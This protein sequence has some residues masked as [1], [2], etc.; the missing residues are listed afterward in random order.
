MASVFG[1]EARGRPGQLGSGAAASLAPRRPPFV[2]VSALIAS[3][4]GLLARSPGAVCTCW[5]RCQA[6]RHPGRA[7]ARRMTGVIYIASTWVPFALPRTSPAFS[8]G[9]NRRHFAA[10]NEIL[11]ANCS[12]GRCLSG[13][14]REDGS[15]RG[16]KGRRR[17]REH[18]WG[19]GGV[20]RGFLK[21]TD[22]REGVEEGRGPGAGDRGE[23]CAN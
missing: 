1:A 15:K 6:A 18:G 7:Q 11:A 14:A 13:K 21:P 2:C 12:R 3:W 22:S 19:E 5:Q 4:S 10:N 16:G 9:G 20:C 17:E 23:E 8:R